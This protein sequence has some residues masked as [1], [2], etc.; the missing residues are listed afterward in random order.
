MGRSREKAEAAITTL[1]EVT[2][3]F[4]VVYIHVDLANVVSVKA[5]AQELVSKERRLDIL[6]NNA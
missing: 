2:G 5:A 1:Q 6:F 4:N 3:R